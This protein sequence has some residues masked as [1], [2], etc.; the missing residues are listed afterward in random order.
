M[1][2]LFNAPIFLFYFLP[3]TLFTGLIA[4]R[5]FGRNVFLGLLSLYSV[6][7]Y[8]Y[9]EFDW[10]FI[11]IFSILF[12]YGLGQWIGASQDKSQ[13]FRKRLAA[14]GVITNLGLLAYY[15]YTNFILENIDRIA[16]T[17]FVTDIALPIGI[18]FF[19]FQQ[20][21]YIIDTY[22]GKTKEGS[23]LR[24]A[25]FI[26]FFPQL[27]AG[28]IVHHSEMF[29]QFSKGLSKRL[30]GNLSIGLAIF[31]VGLAKKVLIADSFAGYATPIFTLADNGGAVTTLQAWQGILAYSLQ[32][33][34]D[35]SG[36]SD[37]AIGI[38]RMFGMKL[39]ENF[40]SPYKS[41]S[42]SE[43]WR[44]WHMTLS[45]FLRDY[46]YIPLGGNR[47]GELRR[48]VNLF[49]TMVLG[50]I[51]HGAGWGFLIWGV[52]HGAFLTVN[53]LF[54]K[55][56]NRKDN[57]NIDKFSVNHILRP[58]FYLT[59][60]CAIIAW[61][62][63]RAQTLDG[64]MTM[65]A[66]MAGQSEEFKAF[67]FDP[68][69]WSAIIAGGILAILAPNTQ[70]LFRWLFNYEIKLDLYAA[71]PKGQN[72]E[73]EDDNLGPIRFKAMGAIFVVIIAIAAV[74][75]LALNNKVSEFIYFQF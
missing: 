64:L 28:P 59:L 40:N 25:F 72:Q 63:F 17:G 34:F 50:G 75:G 15:K 65:W 69:I 1:A 8:A 56:F 24:Y 2:M 37:M 7:F 52:L 20:I 71:A 14:L 68:D 11:L 51:W 31:L 22:Q 74:V 45:R 29:K 12:N 19:T 18:S 21:A 55:L 53:H 32:I 44:R 43:F 60:F 9:T 5:Y 66:A 38:G 3:F 27:I 16:N 23:F 6:I 10:V 39:P 70:T 36:Y 13:K 49:A 4:H 41:S 46:L 67:K 58:G 33:Y 42:I 26:S 48:Y 35:F 61:V 73:A 30:S 54:N 57:A 62:P 47:K